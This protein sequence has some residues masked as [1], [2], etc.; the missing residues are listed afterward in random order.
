MLDRMRAAARRS[1][2][3]PLYDL[4]G[5]S[6]GMFGLAGDGYRQDAPSKGLKRKIAGINRFRG[7]MG[8]PVCAR[9]GGRDEPMASICRSSP[10]LQVIGDGA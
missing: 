9:V 3:P 6:F 7:A 8:V 10:I 1:G 4:G 5:N 2:V